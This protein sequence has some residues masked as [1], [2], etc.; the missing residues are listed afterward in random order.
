MISRIT[1]YIGIDGGGTKTEAVLTDTFG[2]VLHV[3]K[4]GPSN[5]NDIGIDA[6]VELLA[7]LIT[8]LSLG[9][10]NIPLS[11]IS[12]FAG[13]SGALAVKDQMTEM[14][15]EKLPEM[16]AVAVH[17]DVI[18]L[19]AADTPTGDGVC[20]ICGTGSVCFVRQGASLHRVGG[21]GYLLDSAGSGYDIG[22]MA[23]E[24][25]LKACDGRADNS[26]FPL[27]EAVTAH[28]GGRPDTMISH[29]YQQGKAYIA[30]CAPLVFSLAARR[31]PVANGILDKNAEALAESIT[32]ALSHMPQ[33]TSVTVI[34]GGSICAKESPMWMHRIG[35][36]LSSE[37][38]Q[39]A[40]LFVS[41][42]PPVL[43]AQAEA[44][45]LAVGSKRA[46]LFD[47]FRHNFMTTYQS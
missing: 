3:Q 8:E 23:L 13:I 42:A 43:G 30:A 46:G 45:A 7:K 27:L 39:R 17:S 25:A 40:T 21:W 20:L 5:P 31:D 38:K 1:H 16:G 2:R 37:I 4:I 28:L 44:M 36:Y 35:R 32:A 10:G 12:A 29:I 6:S 33:D 26:C 19:L 15:R 11:Q 24:T 22:R 41:D 18:N 14:L 34:L 47:A 9:A